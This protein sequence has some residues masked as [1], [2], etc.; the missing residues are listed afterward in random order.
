[1]IT[2]P[3][4]VE[5]EGRVPY[6]M[7][8]TADGQLVFTWI[9]C[10][11]KPYME[12]FFDETVAR[13]L[14]LPENSNGQMPVTG[15]EVLITH[16]RQIDAVPLAGIIHHISRCGSTLLAQLLCEDRRFTV[17]SEVPLLDD[18]LMMHYRGVN[19]PDFSVQQLFD[20]VL[21]I[22]TQRSDNHTNAFIKADSWHIH[23]HATLRK[24]YPELPAFLLYR[25]P[26]E[27][28]RS[29]KRL[30][31]MHAVPGLMPSTLFGLTEE[32]AL[33]MTLSDY[34]DRVLIS[35]FRKYASILE[36]DV[37]AVALSYHTGALAM[38]SAVLK[39]CGISLRSELLHG[40]EKRAGFHSKHPGQ[41]FAGDGTEHATCSEELYL[42]Y[43][44]LNVAVTPSTP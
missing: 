36:A 22:M 4:S 32:K 11:S 19:H 8:L 15:A 23:F 5:L 7:K 17:L 28:I 26:A 39:K 3:R 30:P 24:W 1:M 34:L 29:H 31:G 9:H 27:V 21:R 12:P 18:L 14:S 20:A 38:Y 35:Y 37:R 16:A 42:L 2:D 6:K 44:R 41:Q 10:G 43:E 13:C 25:N 33:Q 40:I